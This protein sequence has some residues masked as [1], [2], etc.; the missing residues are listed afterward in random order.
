MLLGDYIKK[1][2]YGTMRLLANDSGVSYVTVRNATRG[3]LIKHYDVAKALSK[4][5]G[6]VVSIPELCETVEE[7][8]KK[9]RVRRYK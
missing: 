9:R 2:G 6:G 7:L 4:A 8:L 1:H 5:T 3:M